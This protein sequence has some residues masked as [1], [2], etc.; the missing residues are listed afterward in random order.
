MR[1][2][3]LDFT[4][5]ELAQAAVEKGETLDVEAEARR[6]IWRTRTSM[7]ASTK[8]WRPCERS[9]QRLRLGRSS[10]SR[11]HI[12]RPSGSRRLPPL[13]RRQRAAASEITM[14]PDEPAIS[15][16]STSGPER[17]S[18]ASCPSRAALH[19]EWT[20]FHPRR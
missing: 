16:P 13:K 11:L 1:R 20:A 7:R 17:T 4:A 19:G 10:R 5:A 14:V 15:T 2:L 18:S 12:L 9:L 8:S 3:V 6:L